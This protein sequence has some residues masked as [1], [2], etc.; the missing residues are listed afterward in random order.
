[1]DHTK[2]RTLDLP[3]PRTVKLIWI[4]IRKSYVVERMDTFSVGQSINTNRLVLLERYVCVDTDSEWE[5][6]VIPEP[7]RT[8]VV[9]GFSSVA[10]TERQPI[11]SERHKSCK[12]T[13][14][15]YYDYL[16][17]NLIWLCFIL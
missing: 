2:H 3:L 10:P 14:S 9:L 11:C 12:R 6:D 16:V 1:L 7:Q 13:P 15:S 17:S 5:N 4:P 8:L